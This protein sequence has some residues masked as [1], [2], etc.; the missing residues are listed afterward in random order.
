MKNM[1]TRS[2]VFVYPTDTVWGM[3]TSIFD[4]F[5]PSKI[6]SIKG[7][8]PGK[9]LSILFADLDELKTCFE[10]PGNI[11]DS[12]L[13]KLFEMESTLG[14]PETW[15]TGKIPISVYQHFPHICVRLIDCEEIHELQRKAK[16]P[17]TTTSMNLTG[18]PP[19]V[20]ASEAELFFQK[21]CRDGE[22]IVPRG[23]TQSGHS[24][25]MIFLNEDLTWN[26]VREGF[27]KNDIKSHME[28]FSA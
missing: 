19:I 5:G 8:D 3:G 22:F 6:A 23:L 10:I 12:W 14:I 25:T 4:E 21:Y 2:G 9:P 16:G 20:D 7:T 15:S 11:N 18:A 27:F 28:L 17:V 13:L 24:S 1:D 26:M